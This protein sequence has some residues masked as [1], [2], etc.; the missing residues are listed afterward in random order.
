MIR[1]LIR[2]RFLRASTSKKD[3]IYIYIIIALIRQCFSIS[4]SLAVVLLTKNKH[5]DLTEDARVTN[6]VFYSLQKY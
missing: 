2:F 3:I 5:G 1:F 4:N 6:A